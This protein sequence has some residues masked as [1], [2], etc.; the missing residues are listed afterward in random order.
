MNQFLFGSLAHLFLS[1][2]KKD[3]S[4]CDVFDTSGEEL[5]FDNFKENGKRF[6]CDVSSDNAGCKRAKQID[7]MDSFQ[8]SPSSGL[9]HIYTLL[10]FCLAFTL[11]NIRYIIPSTNCF[12]IVFSIR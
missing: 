4:R 6:P 12:F 1:E 10:L 5:T 2:K 3:C 7:N 8:G 9:K 11:L